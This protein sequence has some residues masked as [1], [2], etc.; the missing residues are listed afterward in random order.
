MMASMSI[1]GKQRCPNWIITDA[2]CF[3]SEKFPCLSL[4]QMLLLCFYCWKNP[5]E[6]WHHK[7]FS[8]TD[9]HCEGQY[10]RWLIKVS[11]DFWAPDQK[12]ADS[13]HGWLWCPYGQRTASDAKETL[14]ACCDAGSA[15]S[16]LV[17]FV[18]PVSGV[19]AASELLKASLF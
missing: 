1:L 15:K 18:A 13:S 2:T 14:S 17:S 5:A 19:H 3:T 4:D 6:L 7:L 9:Q 11:W 8:L 10:E 16:F 12:S